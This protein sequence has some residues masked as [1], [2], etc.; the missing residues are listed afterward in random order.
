MGESRHDLRTT[1]A[2]LAM[3][4]ASPLAS[5]ACPSA[6][7]GTVS[8]GG[9]TLSAQWLFDAQ[10]SEGRRARTWRHAWTGI[11]GALA[12]GQFALLPW[13]STDQRLELVVGGVGSTASAAFTWFL[14][15]E[16]EATLDRKVEAKNPCE[17][18][19]IEE[20]YAAA[21]STDEA[22]RVTWPWHLGNLGA[23]LLYMTIVGV[24]TGRWDKAALDGVAAFGLGELQLLT[25]PTRLASRLETYGRRD[26]AGQA[27]WWFH[28]VSGGITFNVGAAF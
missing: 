5:A 13:A 26:R 7:R 16:V 1:F 25:Q 28:P 27:A 2:A 18:L 14:P 17:R 10:M 11:N 8:E 12:V 15:L 21:G 9:S 19:R 22:G 24:G 20:Q 23:G 4:A 6:V 3:V